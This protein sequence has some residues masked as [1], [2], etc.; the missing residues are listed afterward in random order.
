[1][2]GSQCVVVIP[3]YNEAET[4]RLT[5]E[6]VLERPLDARVLVVDD[7][8]PDGTG[9][10]VESLATAHPGRIGVLHRAHK[11]GLGRAYVAGFAAALADGEPSIVVQMDADGSHDPGDLD[12]LVAALGD[13]DLAIGSRYIPGG[14]TAGLTRPRELLSRAG[15]RYAR[16][17]LGTGV[18]DL[19]GGFK[20]W[21]S[22]LLRR[23]DIDAVAAD[24]YAFQI[25]LTVR[26][27][28]CGA[29]ITEV[30]IAFR[31]RRAGTSKMNWRIAAE[32]IALVPWM[33]T[34]NSSRHIHIH[35]RNRADN[36]AD[37]DYPL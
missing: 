12:S 18:R 6:Q 17:V 21:R 36:L 2:T 37:S 14:S 33:A 29:R 11:A 9:Q 23:V 34:R 4:I 5:V 31:E 19:T 7:N 10:V 35:R 13:H 15:N 28:R 20:A 25:E 3:T 32:A 30:P 26:A 22:S 27:A 16:L 8:S 24:G 1:M